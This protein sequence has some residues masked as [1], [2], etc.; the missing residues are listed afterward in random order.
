MSHLKYETGLKINPLVYHYT[1]RH[2]TKEQTPEHTGH[3]F[4]HHIVNHRTNNIEERDNNDPN[5]RH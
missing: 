5:T 2:R 4:G 3:R 1:G